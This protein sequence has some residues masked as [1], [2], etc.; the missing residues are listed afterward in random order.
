M[1]KNRRNAENEIKMFRKS[2]KSTITEFQKSKLFAWLQNSLT[3]SINDKVKTSFNEIIQD[4]NAQ[5]SAGNEKVSENFPNKTE[6]I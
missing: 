5:S 6:N 3:A 4:Y 2:R 1:N